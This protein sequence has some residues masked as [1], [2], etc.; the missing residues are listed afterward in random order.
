MFRAPCGLISRL[1]A[2]DFVLANPCS[3]GISLSSG[4][5]KLRQHWPQRCVIRLD[6]LISSTNRCRGNRAAGRALPFH[7]HPLR[8]PCVEKP[9]EDQIVFQHAARQ[10]QRSRASVRSSAVG[11]C[12][13]GVVKPPFLPASPDVADRARRIEAF[14]THIDTIHDRGSERGD[15]DLR[16]CRPL[17][18]R[19]V[20]VGDEAVSRQQSCG[21]DELVGI[22]ERRT[23]GR[24]ACARMHS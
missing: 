16:D 3:N 11:G 2:R 19:L 7:R 22:P 15:R 23:G 10:R 13:S 5:A 1:R 6:D 18:G 24:A 21:T 8:R 12:A 17:V 4:C 9:R 20:A 14:R